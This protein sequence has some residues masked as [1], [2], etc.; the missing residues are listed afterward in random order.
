VLG[1]I[2]S[3]LALSLAF[4]TMLTDCG[5]EDH[6]SIPS[7]ES[8]LPEDEGRSTSIRRGPT[9][10]YQTALVVTYTGVTLPKTIRISHPS[11]Q[12][13]DFATTGGRTRVVLPGS[14]SLSGECTFGRLDGDALLPLR[15][16]SLTRHDDRLQEL[17]K[18]QLGE[19]DR[20]DRPQAPAL[21]FQFSD[22]ADFSHCSAE[23]YRM[24]VLSRSGYR[25]VPSRDGDATCTEPHSVRRVAKDGSVAG[26]GNS[27]P[28][29]LVALRTDDGDLLALWRFSDQRVMK[30]RPPGALSAPAPSKRSRS[31]RVEAL[32]PGGQRF[33]SKWLRFL[34]FESSSFE[35]VRPARFGTSLSRRPGWGQSFVSL[36]IFR[37][38]F[39]AWRGS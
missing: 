4:A 21:K 35:E 33:G 8:V 5:G 13:F 29:D 9:L 30:N 36:A 22:L 39:R 6:A 17:W 2:V 25:P 19:T 28:N 34:A 24:R 26:W 20:S 38:G 32:I 16:E 12:S 3:A 15:L 23:L 1:A 27:S 14:F 31:F 37:C 11:G 18:A 7:A 10:A